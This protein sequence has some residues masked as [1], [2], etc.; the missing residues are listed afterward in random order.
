[1]ANKTAESNEK[2]VYWRLLYV[3]SKEVGQQDG[4]QN[5]QDESRVVLDVLGLLRYVLYSEIVCET[6]NTLYRQSYSQLSGVI[7]EHRCH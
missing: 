2:S 7:R 6:L 3:F 1:M 4:R 5:C